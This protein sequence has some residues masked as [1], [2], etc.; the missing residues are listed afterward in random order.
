MQGKTP[1]PLFNAP[2]VKPHIFR[3]GWLH[4]SDQGVAADFAGNALKLLTSKFP[5]RKKQ[6][7]VQAL[8]AD[9]N[10]W[11]ERA[12]INVPHG[13]RLPCLPP[14]MIQGDKKSPK[15][16]GNAGIIRALVPYLEEA[17]RLRL[18]LADPIEGAV[19]RAAAD[20]KECYDALS[21]RQIFHE[22]LLRRHSRQF[23]LQ[24]VALAQVHQ[25]TRDWKIKPKLHVWLELCSEGSRPATFWTYRD[26]D[27]G[28]G[29]ARMA[30]HRGGRPSVAATSAQVLQSFRAKQPIIRI[31]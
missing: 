20:L 30:R 13:D 4:A 28:G 26:E 7:R 19:R 31:M 10:A 27:Y 25:G 6:Q 14:T 16:R 24:Y 18:N 12:D 15:L 8:F 22:D 29:V 17:T 1:S 23:A 2:W 3:R 21:H 11:Y 5:G 9:I